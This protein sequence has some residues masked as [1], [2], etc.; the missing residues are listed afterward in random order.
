MPN[1]NAPSDNARMFSRHVCTHCHWDR[2]IRATGEDLPVARILA[3]VII[4]DPAGGSFDQHRLSSHLQVCALSITVSIL[5]FG[6]LNQ[7][8]AA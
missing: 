3:R 6:N 5:T 8:H 4:V 7:C 1:V 2:P